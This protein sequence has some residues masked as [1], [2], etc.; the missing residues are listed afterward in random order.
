MAGNAD[1]HSTD[2]V[3]HHCCVAPLL[4]CILAVCASVLSVP[5]CRQRAGPLPRD[6]D[7]VGP[8]AELGLYLPELNPKAPDSAVADNAMDTDVDVVAQQR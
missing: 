6:M 4:C 5:T 8:A 2:V 3:L 1:A 7:D